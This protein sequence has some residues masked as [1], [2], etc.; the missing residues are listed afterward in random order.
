MQ[1]TRCQ[2]VQTFINKGLRLIC[3]CKEMDMTVPVAALWRELQVPPVHA[4]ASAR[5]ARAFF[6]YPHMKT[7]IA[8]ILKYPFRSG[9]ARVGWAA[10]SR[11][12]LS[13]YANDLIDSGNA[14]SR[15]VPYHVRPGRGAYRLVLSLTWERTERLA[16]W[17][18]SKP[19]RDRGFSETSWAAVKA[20]PGGARTEQVTL[21]RGMRAVSL[22]RVGS[23][24]T[25]K[26][27]ARLEL[28]HRKYKSQCPCCG[29]VGEGETIEHILLR[30]SKWAEQREE[31]LGD[32]ILQDD[33]EPRDV[34]TIL[35]GGEHMGVR[36]D[37]WLP[38]RLGEE[39]DY[40]E[41]EQVSC[42]VYS[43]ARFMQS[44]ASKRFSII[45]RL[46]QRK[47]RLRRA[48]AQKGRARP[49]G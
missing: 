36:M 42:G 10:A 3:G 18:A 8:S 1:K 20:I 38:K 13:R 29:E 2:G 40:C 44:I 19:Y 11:K 33:W 35:L 6:K 22:C 7:W 46:E 25:S 27:L 23:F 15:T 41:E 28:V 21:G 12:W 4:M 14:E 47:H 9:W 32:V 17:S 5:R 26:K 49:V 31:Y 30:C 48:K 43:V 45:S 16:A 34:C 39:T 37:D 24:W